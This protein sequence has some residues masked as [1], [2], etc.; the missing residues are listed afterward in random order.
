MK[1]PYNNIVSL[2]ALVLTTSTLTH[3][4]QIDEEIPDLEINVNKKALGGLPSDIMD[5]VI[6]SFSTQKIERK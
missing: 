4:M 2:T 6:S 1:S 5:D 3:G